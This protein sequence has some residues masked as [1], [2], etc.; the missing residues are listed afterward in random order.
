MEAAKERSSRHHPLT[1]HAIGAITVKGKSQPVPVFQPIRLHRTRPSYSRRHP[2][3]RS[4]MEEVPDF[5]RAQPGNQ[6]ILAED[7]QLQEYQRDLLAVIQRPGSASA[8]CL[9]IGEPVCAI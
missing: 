1:F 3:D 4:M 7:T 5:M 6:L 9:L 2:G 8:V